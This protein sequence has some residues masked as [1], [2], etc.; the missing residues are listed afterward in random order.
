ML[1]PAG[2]EQ[3]LQQRVGEHAVVEDL[4]K[5]VQRHLTASVLEQRGHAPNLSQAPR[6]RRA[7]PTTG[8]RTKPNRL[9]AAAG[10]LTGTLPE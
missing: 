10:T 3:R 7:K 1:G 8:P 5:A 6:C 4:L 9:G 2:P